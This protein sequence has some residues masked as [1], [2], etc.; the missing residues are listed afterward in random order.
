[1]N[2]LRQIADYLESHGVYPTRQRLAVGELVFDKNRHFS[3]EQLMDRLRLAGKEAAQVSRATVYNTLG[4][5]VSKG[6]L[7]EITIDA[8]RV[9]YDSNVAH[10][11]HVFD[12][13]TNELT[14]LDK[15]CVEHEIS[16]LPENCVI[17]G[18]DVVVRTRRI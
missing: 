5:F 1:M 14:D 6:M 16:G 13:D 2:K 9:F 8:N 10:H 17:E 3:A 11:H 7:R 18:V 15:K 12:M 4:L